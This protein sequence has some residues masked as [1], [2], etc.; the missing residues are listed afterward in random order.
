MQT[1][2]TL[3]PPL[4]A[5]SAADAAEFIVTCLERLGVEYV[6]GI[7]GGA[8]EPLYDALARSERRIPAAPNRRK[9][10]LVCWRGPS[11]ASPHQ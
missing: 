2:L 3:T 1:A 11:V 6:F 8:I 5:P 4:P 7:P 9:R 10:L